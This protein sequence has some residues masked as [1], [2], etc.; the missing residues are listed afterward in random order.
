[1]TSR[2]LYASE[3]HSLLHQNED[4]FG[5][6][7]EPVQEGSDEDF[8]YSCDSCAEASDDSGS[9]DMVNDSDEVAVS[10]S[11]EY[12]PQFRTGTERA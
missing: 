6:V 8:D 2:K 12:I 5:D 7:Y 11:D 10:D 3:V 1:M 9:E 4:D